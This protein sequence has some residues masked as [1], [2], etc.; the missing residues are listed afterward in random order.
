[1][2]TSRLSRIFRVESHVDGS[3][4]QA[5]RAFLLVACNDQQSLP[6]QRQRTCHRNGT[7]V[8]PTDKGIQRMI[9]VLVAFERTETLVSRKR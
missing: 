2:R 3:D 1:M 7:P 6:Q 9:T 5:F 8:W 4:S